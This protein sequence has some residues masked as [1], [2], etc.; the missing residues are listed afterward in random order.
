MTKGLEL[1]EL[2]VTF[3]KTNIAPENRWLENEMSV[4][5]LLIFDG[6]VYVGGSASQIH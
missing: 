1:A 5:G 3:P 2:V 6:R 4:L